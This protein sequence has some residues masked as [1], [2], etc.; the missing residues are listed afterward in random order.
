MQHDT[1]HLMTTNTRTFAD[2][3][4]PSDTVD[5]PELRVYEDPELLEV[6]HDGD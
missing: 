3:V 1:F 2:F 6:P 4:D 5:E